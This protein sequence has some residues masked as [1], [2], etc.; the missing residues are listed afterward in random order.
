MARDNGSPPLIS[1]VTVS[2]LISDVNDNSPQILYP[3]L[4]GNSFMTE[5]VPKA[6][7]GGSLSNPL[8]LDFSLLVSTAENQDTAGHF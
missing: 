5:L 7:H 4:E 6:A 1:N 2:V 3:A 8:I